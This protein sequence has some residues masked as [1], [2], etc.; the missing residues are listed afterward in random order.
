[1]SHDPNMQ[2]SVNEFNSRQPAK[3]EGHAQTSCSPVSFINKHTADTLMRQNSAAIF[4]MLTDYQK[5]SRFWTTTKTQLK[6]IGNLLSLFH[7]DDR[8]I[9]VHHSWCHKT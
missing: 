9:K 7:Q 4:I 5:T 8:E 6:V 3:F 2:S 1:M